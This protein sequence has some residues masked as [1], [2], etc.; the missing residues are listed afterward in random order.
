MYVKINFRGKPVAEGTILFTGFYGDMK[1]WGKHVLGKNHVLVKV[2]SIINGNF[3][4]KP[5]HDSWDEEKKI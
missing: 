2:E 5:R 4:P 1:K 3:E